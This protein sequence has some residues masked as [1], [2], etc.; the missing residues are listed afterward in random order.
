L[1]HDSSKATQALY[2]ANKIVNTFQPHKENSIDQA[3]LI[4]K[5]F[6]KHKNGSNDQF[7]LTAVGN[8]H[9]DTAWLW[10]FDETKRK[11]ARSWSTQVGLM[12]IYPEYKFVGSQAQQFEWLKE[13][14]PKLFKQIQEKAVN[15]QF[16]PIGGV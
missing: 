8:C 9:I 12:N 1:P 4:S 11:V 3:L 16:L 7:K 14:Y 2:A 15:G 13:L 10:P 6:L 5:E